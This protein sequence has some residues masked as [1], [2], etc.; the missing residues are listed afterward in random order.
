MQGRI[1]V[2]QRVVGPS[3]K[4]LSPHPHTLRVVKGT[5]SKAVNPSFGGVK[6]KKREVN[7]N[8]RITLPNGGVT[9]LSDLARKVKE[10]D[11]QFY[12]PYIGAWQKSSDFHR[13]M[14]IWAKK[15]LRR[16]GK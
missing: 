15:V 3:G 7:M 8:L 2:F 9:R 1:F 11:I 16:R 14:E 12:N 10:E 13:S 6:N 5:L 4:Q